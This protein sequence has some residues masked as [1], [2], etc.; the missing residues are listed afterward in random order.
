[1]FVDQLRE[2]QGTG[3]ACRTATDDDDVGLHLRAGDVFERLAE[4]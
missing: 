2:A 1:M 4:D 3:H